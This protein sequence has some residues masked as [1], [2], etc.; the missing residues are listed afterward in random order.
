MT[1]ALA[2]HSETSIGQKS[3]VTFA[4]GNAKQID[5]KTFFFPQNFE[6]KKLKKMTFLF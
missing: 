2:Y 3:F 5:I 4:S 1:N 6:Q